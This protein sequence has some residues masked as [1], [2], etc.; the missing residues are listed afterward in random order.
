VTGGER[1]AQIALEVAL[2]KSRFGRDRLQTRRG[3]L[4]WALLSAVSG[5]VAEEITIFQTKD[6]AKRGSECRKPEARTRVLV[7]AQMK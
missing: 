2:H 7:Q 3:R 6:S 5:Q 1:E 4:L